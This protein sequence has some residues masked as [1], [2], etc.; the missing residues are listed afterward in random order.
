MKKKSKEKELKSRIKAQASRIKKL[1]KRIGFLY[2]LC[3]HYLSGRGELSD[4]AEDKEL[5]RFFR[6]ISALAE[7]KKGEERTAKRL[8]SELKVKEYYLSSKISEVEL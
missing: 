5:R 8:E 4:G 7:E 3:G 6:R 1:D 2:R